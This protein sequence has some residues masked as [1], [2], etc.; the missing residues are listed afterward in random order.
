MNKEYIQK[1]VT[2]VN[3]DNN[4]FWAVATIIRREL[5]I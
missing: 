3:K 2:A 5:T 1:S 4:M